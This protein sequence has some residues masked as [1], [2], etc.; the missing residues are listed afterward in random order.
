MKKTVIFA[1]FSFFIIGCTNDMHYV[2]PIEIERCTEITRSQYIDSLIMDDIE[3]ILLLGV[4]TTN[5]LIRDSYY[6]ADG[7]CVP[8]AILDEPIYQNRISQNSA[9]NSHFYNIYYKLPSSSSIGSQL[10]NCFVTAILEWSVLSNG[11]GLNILYGPQATTDKT[12]FQVNLNLSRDYRVDDPLVFPVLESMPQD[13]PYQN[14]IINRNNPLWNQVSSNHTQF[15]YL[16]MHAVGESLKFD[17]IDYYDE[18]DRSIMMSEHLLATVPD[19]WNGLSRNDIDGIHEAFAVAPEAMFTYAWSPSIE[20]DAIQRNILQ[21]NVAYILT[22]SSDGMCCQSVGTEFHIKIMKHGASES[23][24]IG[25]H[26]YGTDSF[27]IT[28]EESGYYSL[29]VW[30]ND[31]GVKEL[32]KQTI[33]LYV[34]ENEF[35]AAPSAS[36]GLNCATTLQYKYYHPDHQN[37]TYDF[38]VEEAM[39]GAP[40]EGLVQVNE[41]VCIVTPQEYGCYYVD[42][43]VKSDGVEIDRK[44]YNLTVLNDM[45]VNVE[46][47]YD[48]DASDMRPRSMYDTYVNHYYYDIVQERPSG[49]NARTAYFFEYETE[50]QTWN[51]A[52]NRAVCRNWFLDYNFIIFAEGETEKRSVL[53]MVQHGDMLSYRDAYYQYY[54]GN[55]YCPMNGLRLVDDKNILSL[56][57]HRIIM[58]IK[59]IEVGPQVAR[60]ELN[61]VSSDIVH[62]DY[63]ENDDQ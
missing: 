23:N 25:S 26:I 40:L 53:Q 14:I 24:V 52:P 41:N 5:L 31:S 44:T 35:V 33:D 10:Y 54:T 49:N 15:T 51:E 37:I 13:V 4:D 29:T 56:P 17:S 62:R 48:L 38:S 63:D 22:I 60:P 7:V 59:N 46:M 30:A 61:I 57:M 45:G 3:K 58:P 55:V 11:S 18:F 16:V 32:H 12:Y 27:S 19:L 2:Q 20:V 42:A 50:T 6:I 21:K 43:I 34:V 28:F 36:V 1:L 39:F 47:I 9:I 8:K